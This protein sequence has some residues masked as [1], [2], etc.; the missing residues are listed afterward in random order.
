MESQFYGRAIYVQL[1]VNWDRGL[2]GQ[3]DVPILVDDSINSLRFLSNHPKNGL[4]TYQR[5][6][7]SL[8]IY[9]FQEFLQKL[10]SVRQLK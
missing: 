6:L 4:W 8:R 1:V 3:F 7:I 10:Y 9:I 5:S 2:S